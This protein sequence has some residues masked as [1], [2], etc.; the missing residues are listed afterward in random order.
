MGP[1]ATAQS[2]SDDPQGALKARIAEVTSDG[3]KLI[4]KGED[5]LVIRRVLP[6]RSKLSRKAA[7]EATE[8]QL[9]AANL[10]AV[11]VVTALPLP[12][13]KERSLP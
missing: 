6:R 13:R 12:V 11:L 5:T 3:S 2:P 4:V 9:I 8:E 1:A 7:G 10:D